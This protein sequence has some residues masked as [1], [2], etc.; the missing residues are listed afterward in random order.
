MVNNKCSVAFCPVAQHGLEK[1]GKSRGNVT[2]FSFPKDPETLAKWVEAVKRENFSPTTSSRI[3]EIHFLKE[4]FI[5]PKNPNRLHVVKRLREGSVP[6]RH[7]GTG[8]GADEVHHP[9][10]LLHL[11]PGVE[12][13]NV[14]TDG[15][16]QFETGEDGGITLRPPDVEQTIQIAEANVDTI[17]V[18]M[19][20]A[21]S[22]EVIETVEQAQV[23]H[24]KSL[25]PIKGKRDVKGE[26]DIVPQD[27][28]ENTMEVENGYFDR[29]LVRRK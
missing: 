5:P 20:E 27:V 8:D 14:V 24:L 6:T 21:P 15:T 22:S 4:N 18:K 26:V 19:E 17:I 13:E 10:N 9:S 28:M 16:V 23:E 1:R 29:F 11:P 2:H 3:C 25:K 7:L 12:F